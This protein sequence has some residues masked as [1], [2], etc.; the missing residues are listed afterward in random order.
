[1]TV[2]VNK[3]LVT[4][5]FIL[6]AIAILIPIKHAQ[7][8]EPGQP[9]GRDFV[10][11]GQKGSLTGILVYQNAEWFLRAGDELYA[12]HMGPRDFM[13]DQ[14]FVLRAGDQASIKA[15]FHN[16]DAAVV[17][18]TTN[19][20]TMVL[21]DSSGRPAWSGTKYSQRRNYGGGQGQGQGL[22]RNRVSQ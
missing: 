16:Q 9:S 5:L 14:G 2:R 20:R 21:R 10:Q 17:E 8:A 13:T 15:F 11:V 22:G 18:I 4:T 3:A 7:A 19:G 6:A 1:M 12:L